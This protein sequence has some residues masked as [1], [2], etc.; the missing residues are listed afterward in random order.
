MR[1]S[2][3]LWLRL[4]FQPSIRCQGSEVTPLPGVTIDE[5]K[6]VSSTGALALKEVPAKMVVVGGGIIGLEMGSVWSRL[7]SAVTVVEFLPNIVPAMDAEVRKT[8]QRAL[9]KQKMKFKLGY[10]VKSAEVQGDGVTLAIE[11][12]GGGDTE[13]LEA[14]VVLVAIGR[15]PHTEGLGL[16]AAGVKLNDRGRVEVDSSFR[17]SVPSIYAIGDVIEGPM[18]AHKA[19]EDGIACV[20]TIA[21]KHGHVN[22]DTVPSIVYTHPEMAWVGLTEE[23]VKEKGIEYTIGKFPFA[24]NSR[25][26][27]NHDSEG[28][29]KFIADKKTDKI[30]GLHILG[31]NAG[32]L[33]AEGVLAMEYGASSEDIARV[34]HGHPTLTEVGLTTL[35]Q[36]RGSHSTVSAPC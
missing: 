33:I 28:V 3:L 14:D 22:Y 35:S 18:L 1:P 19:E 2:P 6:I 24:A 29:V 26:R 25:A 13:T 36:A 30:L 16:D 15:R 10:A 17:T 9:T 27:T 20:E 4:S 7:G 11:K 12:A 21:G 34:C 31:P 8:F 23:Q 32:E 5:E